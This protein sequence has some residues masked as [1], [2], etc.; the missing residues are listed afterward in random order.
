[1]A[2]CTDQGLALSRASGNRNM[3]TTIVASL[4]Y[5]AALQGRLAEGR[6]LLEE[7]IRESLSTGA[8]HAVHWA[9][10]SEVCRLA[11]R[12]EDAWQHAARTPGSTPT[13]RSTWPGSR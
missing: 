4:G 13:R 6:T 2:P 10:L 12:G 1:M 11:G 3:L 9:W 5:A 8:C 7:A